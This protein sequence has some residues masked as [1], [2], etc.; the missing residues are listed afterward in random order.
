[1]VDSDKAWDVVRL[2]ILIVDITDNCKVLNIIDIWY[3]EMADIWDGTKDDI[4]TVVNDTICD[5]NNWPM[6]IGDNEIICD[7]DNI[8]AIW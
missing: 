5:V 1:M 2:Y 7:V 3:V 4:C 6:F 8:D